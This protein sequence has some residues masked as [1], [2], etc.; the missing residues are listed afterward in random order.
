MHAIGGHLVCVHWGDNDDVFMLVLYGFNVLRY[1]QLGGVFVLF[2][3]SRCDTLLI[4][5]S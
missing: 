3:Y 4:G 2:L 1:L 5:G